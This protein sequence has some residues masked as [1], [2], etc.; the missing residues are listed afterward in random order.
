MVSD[1]NKMSRQDLLNCVNNRKNEIAEKL[2]SGETEE[3]FMIGASSYTIKE[4]DN[5]I[6]KID[7]NMEENKEQQEEKKKRTIG[8]SI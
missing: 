8:E 7:K 6:N 5:L 2:K 4:W 1:I 3:E